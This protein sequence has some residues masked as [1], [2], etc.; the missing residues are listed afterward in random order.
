MGRLCTRTR[1]PASPR[2]TTSG[3][4]HR[5]AHPAGQ[6]SIRSATFRELWIKLGQVEQ[7]FRLGMSKAGRTL[8]E[9]GERPWACVLWAFIGRQLTIRA[10][11][12]GPLTLDVLIDR[13]PTGCRLVR[14]INNSR[15][16]VD[17]GTP[18]HFQTC[19]RKEVSRAF[20]R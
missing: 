7:D 5:S 20:P 19:R 18:S 2:R 3:F 10:K 13:P 15:V 9:S 6:K 11:S 16:D 8:R 14:L 17:V 1:A 4:Q 12:S